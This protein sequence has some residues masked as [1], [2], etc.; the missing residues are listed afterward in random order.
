M[1]G[2]TSSLAEVRHRLD[3]LVEQR[4]VS[5]LSV[6]EETEY[7]DLVSVESA[8]LAAAPPRSGFGRRARGDI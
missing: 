2:R 8:L 3:Q 5:G 6:A 7:R 1:S 4:T